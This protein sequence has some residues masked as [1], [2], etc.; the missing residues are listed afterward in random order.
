LRRQGGSEVLRYGLIRAE[1]PLGAPPSP[2]D[3][4]LLPFSQPIA[5]VISG[6][7]NVSQ[8]MVIQNKPLRGNALESVDATVFEAYPG[9]EG[10][11]VDR[12]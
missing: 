1:W 10:E 6:K 2:G 7:A 3:E 8:E 5:E 9:A 12:T 4:L 11:V